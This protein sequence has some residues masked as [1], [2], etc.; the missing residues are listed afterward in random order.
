M[1]ADNT[2]KTVIFCVAFLAAFITFVALIPS[3]FFIS[4][5]DYTQ[6]DIPDY[7]TQEDIQHIKHFLNETVFTPSTTFDFNTASNPVNYKFIFVWVVFGG[8]PFH[9]YHINWEWWIFST[10]HYMELT[11]LE[12]GITYGDTVTK[13]QAL[14]NYDAELNASIFYPAKCMDITVKLWL[15]DSNQT[16]N[17]LGEAWDASECEAA[18]GFGYE[19]YE[20]KLS[21]WDIVGRLL[22]FQSPEV[23]GATGATALA[24][25]LVVGIPF[26]AAVA[27]CIYLLF[28]EAVP[29]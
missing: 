7:F 24:L 4:S 8:T 11:G 17:D 9:L 28:M 14:A 3:A 18:I 12:T 6:F 25:N 13:A 2:I 16:R 22:T 21:A 15:Y 27:V 5:K 23:F 19:D 20:T 26:W 29:F 1:A 10:A